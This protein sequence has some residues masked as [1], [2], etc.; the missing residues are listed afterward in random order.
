MFILTHLN[1]SPRAGPMTKT[2]KVC[3]ISDIPLHEMRCVSLQD[4]NVL[5]AHTDSGFFVSDEMCTHEDARLCD[6]NLNGTLV[7]CPLHGSRFDLV[8]G[9]VLDDPAD[10]D[11]MV[12]PVTIEDD[13]VYITI[14][15]DNNDNRA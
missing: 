13:T 12:Y 10:E 1:D 8:S 2:H 6:G 3:Q 4:R 15:T 11:L 14:N 7:K 5:V 9:K